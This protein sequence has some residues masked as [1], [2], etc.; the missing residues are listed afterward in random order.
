LEL[1]VKEAAGTVCSQE[2]RMSPGGGTLTG[3]NLAEPRKVSYVA[4]QAFSGEYEVKVRR[5]WG[6]P[7]GNKAR[8]EIIRHQGTAREMRK[9]QTISVDEPVVT[10][11]VKLDEGRRT[12]LAAIA[13][14]EYRRPEAKAEVEKGVSTLERLRD[15]ADPYYTG[16]S[17]GLRSTLSRPSVLTREQAF[18][19]GNGKKMDNVLYQTGIAPQGGT[20]LSLNAQV[21]N[22]NQGPGL[23][24]NPVFQ[25]GAFIPRGSGSTL[26]GIPG[27]GN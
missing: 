19:T 16:Q 11:T 10:L 8:V 5:L 24:I 26:P 14:V 1:W 27:G 23:T 7:L 9:I 18:G 22:T 15:L 12:S 21:V 2:H 13:P 17:G 3:G 25:R 6:Q 4:A 20:G